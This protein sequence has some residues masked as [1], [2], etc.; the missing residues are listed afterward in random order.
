MSNWKIPAPWHKAHLGNMQH[1]LEQGTLRLHYACEVAQRIG[2]RAWTMI[3]LLVPMISVF[4]YLLVTLAQGGQPKDFPVTMGALLIFGAP[5]VVLLFYA[6][7]ILFPA[8]RFAEGRL[9]SEALAEGLLVNEQQD[10]VIRRAMLSQELEYLDASIRGNLAQNAKRQRH[11]K[12][13]MLL[14]C[15]WFAATVIGLSYLAL[16]Q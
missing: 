6:V 4:L 13:L 5:L 9:P 16:F 15:L 14:L 1:A 2:Q 8:N 11:L 12:L 10:E 7:Y 3:T